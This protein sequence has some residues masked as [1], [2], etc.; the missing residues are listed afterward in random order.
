MSSRRG[1][2]EGGIYQRESDGKWCATIDLGFVNGKRR[3]KV[4][5]GTTRKEVAEKLRGLQH[6]Q[7]RGVPLVVER[8]TVEE[9]LNRWLETIVRPH[10]RPKTAAS[11]DEV[12]QR[13]LIPRLGRYQLSR[14]SPE[15]VQAA[16]NN[17][18]ARGRR[19]GGP[20][21]ART[22][23]YAQ[24][25][26]QRALN[27][28]LRW[29]LITRNVAILVETPR[30][31]RKEMAVL[32]HEQGQ[33][34]LTVVAGHRYEALYHVA[35]LLGLRKGEILG[36]RWQDIDFAAHTLRVVQSIQRVG[37]KVVIAQPKTS[38]SVRVLP[39]PNKVERVLAMHAERQ[40]EERG[41]R[42]DWEDY[43]LVFPSERGT[44]LEARSLVRH[45]KAALEQADLPEI[46]F[47]D[48]RHSCATMLIAQGVHPRIVMEILGHSQI[49]LT[50]NTY[51]HVLPETRRAASRAMDSLFQANEED[52]A[53]PEPPAKPRKGL[54]TLR[55]RKSLSE[56]YSYAVTF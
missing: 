49:G 47:H 52:T 3:R 13:Y 12:V 55:E 8:Q 51:G 44:P 5:Y 56:R 1:K 50:M 42:E 25:V 54:K 45:F 46:R 27:Q 18:Q 19:N 30:V 16:V 26:L 15:H 48:L 35:L 31:E 28:A 4:I 10:R 9:F 6:D 20:L 7:A 11:Y 38:S 23:E 43:G 41:Q 53:K 24:S 33:R 14:L 37:G 32:S 34:L 29:G 36:L 21:G 2:G 22:V 17:L 40:A 39:M